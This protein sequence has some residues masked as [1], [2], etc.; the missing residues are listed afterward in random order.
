MGHSSIITTAI[1][2]NAIGKEERM[3]AKRLWGG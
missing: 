1:Y 2:L 3:F